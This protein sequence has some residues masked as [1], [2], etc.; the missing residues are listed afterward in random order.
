MI[1][2]RPPLQVRTETQRQRCPAIRVAVVRG[3]SEGEGDS[4]VKHSAAGVDLVEG[5]EGVLPGRRPQGAGNKAS[6][7]A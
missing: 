1:F 7:L 5:E 4:I 3:G 2:T 6:G